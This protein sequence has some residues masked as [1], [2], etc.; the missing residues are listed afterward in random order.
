MIKSGRMRWV[1]HVA[2]M[3]G[4][5]GRRIIFELIRSKVRRCGLIH[6]VQNRDQLQA[7]VNMVLNLQLP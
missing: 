2:H 5:I 1:R 7:V 3:G 4:G 6:L